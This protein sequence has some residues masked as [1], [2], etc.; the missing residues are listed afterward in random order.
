[1]DPQESGGG[2]KMN[3]IYRKRSFWSLAGPLLGYLGIQFAVQ[4]AAQFVIEMPY[5]MQAYAKVLRGSGDTVPS[6]Q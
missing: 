1:M 3:Q 6:M 4:F 2:V 5:I